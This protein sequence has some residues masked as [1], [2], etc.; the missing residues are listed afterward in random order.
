[1]D[2]RRIVVEWY[3]DAVRFLPNLLLIAVILVVT[4][5]FSRRSQGWIRQIAERSQA[6]REIGDLLARIARIAILLIGALIVLG[7]LGLGS[8]VVSFVAGLGIAGIVIGFALQDIVK[9]FA[10]GVLLLMLRPFR[11]GDEIQVGGFEGRVQDV[12]LRATILK[13][14][15]GNEVLIPNADVY[16][17]ALINQSRYH[18]RRQTVTLK[19]PEQLDLARVRAALA[20]ALA[21]VPG[22][23]SNP[24]PSVVAIGLDGAVVTIEA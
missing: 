24:M 19:V 6:P 18:L 5:G 23:A 8:A 7:Q 22:V 3:E 21:E 12:Q 2:I 10:A 20:H 4:I 9:H 1:M 17:S 16:N 15:N 13:T 14:E 11:I